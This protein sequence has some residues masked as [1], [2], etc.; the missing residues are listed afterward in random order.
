MPTI[1]RFTPLAFHRFYN[2]LRGR[3]V[4]DTFPTFYRC[5]SRIDAARCARTAG[6]DVEGIDFVDGRPEYLRL[7]WV[8]YVFGILYERIVSRF[9]ALAPLRAVML[10]QFRKPVGAAS[11]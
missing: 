10:V 8:T 4:I 1:A 6:L 5:N 2:R 7:L 9:G 3:K 11:G